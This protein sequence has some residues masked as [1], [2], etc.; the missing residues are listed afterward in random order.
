M[1]EAEKDQRQFEPTMRRREE[2]RRE[3]RVAVSKDVNSAIQL[4]AMLALFAAM[5]EDAVIAM[6]LAIRHAIERFPQGIAVGQGFADAV[7]ES[8]AIMGPPMLGLAGL[9]GLSAVLANAVQTKGMFASKLLGFRL[10]RINPMSKFKEIF[11]PK[12]ATIRLLLP[13]Y[14]GMR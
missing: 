9:V 3:G 5:G 2:F 4:V 6:G 11:G 14:T 8:V 10:D 1:A 13:C 12:K 7:G